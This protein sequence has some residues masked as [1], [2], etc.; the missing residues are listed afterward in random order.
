MA[1]YYGTYSCGHK[2]RVNIIGPV[3]DRQWKADREFSKMCPECYKQ[4][5]KKQREK[6]I[7]EAKKKA[8]EMKLPE[9][10]GTEKQVAWAIVLR[11]Q[12]INKFNKAMND[13]DYMEYVIRFNPRNQHITRE[14]MIKIRDYIIENETDAK[15]Y[16]D[17]RFFDLLEFIAKYKN[18]AL[19]L[20]EELEAEKEILEEDERILKCLERMVNY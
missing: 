19:R 8:E 5:L 11:N 17:T 15:F 2:G 14:D 20:K 3:K 13:E 6:E 10:I 16:I 7:L 1:W 12:L 4:Y 18:E 9:L